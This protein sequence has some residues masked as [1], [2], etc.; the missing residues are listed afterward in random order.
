MEA[1]TEEEAG[2]VS[3]HNTHN[4][5]IDDANTLGGLVLGEKDL[6]QVVQG[7]AFAS[8]EGRSRFVD[9]RE[10][11]SPVQHAGGF[12]GQHVGWAE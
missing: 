8:K 1:N 5:Y 4:T 10:H 12:V 7:A 9:R 11:V 3:T 2:G 6:G